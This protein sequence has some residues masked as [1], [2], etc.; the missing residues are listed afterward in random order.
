M[1]ALS[2]LS[3]AQAL[4][5]V[6]TQLF[7]SLSFSSGLGGGTVVVRGGIRLG[8]SWLR[9]WLRG[10][11]PPGETLDWGRYVWAATLLGVKWR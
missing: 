8:R 7:P 1:S 4:K 6:K 11:P 9:G 3:Q 10:S 5:T 2:H